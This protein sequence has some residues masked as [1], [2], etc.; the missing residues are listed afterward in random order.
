MGRGELNH[1]FLDGLAMALGELQTS[2]P[3]EVLIPFVGFK[4]GVR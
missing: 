1:A 4:H 2:N 3:S